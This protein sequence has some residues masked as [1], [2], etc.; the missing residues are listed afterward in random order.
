MREK[1]VLGIQ[2][3]GSKILE[4]KSQGIPAL[5]WKESFQDSKKKEMR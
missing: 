4:R 1:K 5:E 3:K 2:R